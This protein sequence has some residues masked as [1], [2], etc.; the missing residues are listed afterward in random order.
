MFGKNLQSCLEK[1]SV[2]AILPEDKVA[3]LTPLCEVSVTCFLTS[4]S[5]FFIMVIYVTYGHMIY[6]S[7]KENIKL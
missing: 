1:S 5:F 4:T 7:Q 3:A 2:I 6:I